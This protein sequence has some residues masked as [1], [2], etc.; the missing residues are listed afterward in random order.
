MAWVTASRG[1]GQADDVTQHHRAQ[2]ARQAAC[3]S[4]DMEYTWHHLLTS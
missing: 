2:R 4:G 3:R 1:K